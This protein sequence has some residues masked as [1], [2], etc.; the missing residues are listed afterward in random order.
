MPLEKAPV[1]SAGF[2]KNVKTEIAAG[3]PQKQAVA[4]AYEKARGDAANDAKADAMTNI[5]AIEVLKKTGDEEK[6]W[7]IAKEDEGLLP[8]VTKE[9]WLKHARKSLAYNDAKPNRAEEIKKAENAVRHHKDKLEKAKKELASGSEYAKDWGRADV[10][11]A[12]KKLAEAEKALAE[13]KARKDASDSRFDVAEVEKKWQI[14]GVS[15]NGNKFAFPIMAFNHGEAKKKA[16]AK[17]KPGDDILDIVLIEGVAERNRAAEKAKSLFK[18]NPGMFGRKD[19]AKADSLPPLARALAA[20]DSMYAK[21]LDSVHR[22]DADN[23]VTSRVTDFNN[24]KKYSTGALKNTMK[25]LLNESA[26]AKTAGNMDKRYDLLEKASKIENHL[27]TRSDAERDLP[28][29][30]TTEG[31]YGID[32][33]RDL[34]GEGT[35]D[36]DARLSLPAALNVLK[37]DGIGE[38][39]SIDILQNMKSAGLIKYNDMSGNYV[40]QS[41]LNKFIRK[42]G[43]R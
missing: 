23:L 36:A 6:A 20:A 31:N 22:K 15:K 24:L 10:I 16:E 12:T 39:A 18:S 32:A 33:E 37:G 4:I 13:L 34:P 11:A 42:H 3:K 41:E 30:G 14:K 9:A 2:E 19:A 1:G 38:N 26:A 5:R 43:K 7:K 29:A 25:L 17:I 35:A 40:L 21:A 27:N 28:G 8:G